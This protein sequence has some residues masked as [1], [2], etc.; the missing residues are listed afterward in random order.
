[1]ECFAPV[2]TQPVRAVVFDFDGTIS[3]LR[4]GWET[5]MEP[6]MLEMIAGK[7]P[8][9]D[10]VVAEVRAYIDE[11]TGVQTIH[12]MKWLAASIT[13]YG[14]NPGMPEDPWFYKG[15]DNRRLMDTVQLRRE[16]VVTG[17]CPA[18]DYLIAGST[19]RSETLQRFISELEERQDPIE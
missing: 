12:Q 7:H 1:M 3:T 5:V 17:E 8:V 15:E 10:A 9:T 6:M 18:D 13:R 16:A 14:L 19:I 4:H 2:S 11:S